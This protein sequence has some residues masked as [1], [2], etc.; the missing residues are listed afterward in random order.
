MEY[1]GPFKQDKNGLWYLDS[2]DIKTNEIFFKE[3]GKSYSK[4]TSFYEIEG[5]D[6]YFI[7]DSTMYPFFFNKS[8][9]LKLLKKLIEKQNKF[10][11][12]DFPFA[13]YKGLGLFK[14]IVNPYY[15]GALSLDNITVTRNFNALKNYYNHESDEI[16]NFQALFLDVLEILHQMYKNNIYY[17]DA[18]LP[19]FV[20]FNN[21]VKIVD[22]EP[23]Y[24]HFKDYDNWHLQ[25]MLSAY[26]SSV[27]SARK[28][29]GFKTVKFNP[30]EDFYE[31]ELNLKSL[32]KRLER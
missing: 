5:V 31:T 22:F 2:K 10:D 27:D 26:A 3:S 11:D 7:K 18:R 13:Y 15:K 1:V 24:V 30:G 9:H 32:C 6:N 20:V 23:G 8:R 19:N 17:T 28:R 21:K 16:D 25:R 14:G 12:I 29:Y 4:R